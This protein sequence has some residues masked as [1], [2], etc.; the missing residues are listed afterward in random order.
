MRKENRE[1]MIFLSTAK[2]AVFVFLFLCP[3]R[4]YGYEWVG[5]LNLLYFENYTETTKTKNHCRKIAS[6]LDVGTVQKPLFNII[7]SGKG[8]SIG[9]KY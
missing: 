9:V 3:V 6:S 4:K 1:N 2:A 5:L 7:Y 8:T